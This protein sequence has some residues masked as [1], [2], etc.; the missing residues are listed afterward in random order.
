MPVV[1]LGDDGIGVVPIVKPKPVPCE[2]GIQLRDPADHAGGSSGCVSVGVN[3]VNQGGYAI[4]IVVRDAIQADWLLTK[5][6]RRETTSLR[7]TEPGSRRR[8]G[9][10]PVMEEN[11]ETS[12]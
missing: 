5:L 4:A 12:A 7:G 3:A 10:I 6:Y 11:W 8:S 9:D 1:K 2:K